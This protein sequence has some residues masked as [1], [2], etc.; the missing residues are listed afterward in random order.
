MNVINLECAGEMCGEPWT[1]MPSRRAHD[2]DDEQPF[3]AYCL[4]SNWQ[5]SSLFT[6]DIPL[7]LHNKCQARGDATA[8]RHSSPPKLLWSQLSKQPDFCWFFS[9]FWTVV[10]GFW[11]LVLGASISI[12]ICRET[13]E[14][15][16]F[17]WSQVCCDW[18]SYIPRNTIQTNFV[19]QIQIAN[20][21]L[22]TCF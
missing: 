5:T 10:S 17:L 13:E 6:P 22:F 14:K 11:L 9:G 4:I 19:S 12:F 18:N 1:P 8:P 7:Y 2:D 16:L 15:Y 20:H 21:C 3:T